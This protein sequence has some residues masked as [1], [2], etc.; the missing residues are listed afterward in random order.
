MPIIKATPADAGCYVEGHWGQYAVAHMVQRAEEYGY[1]SDRTASLKERAHRE[2]I[3]DLAAR[4]L[5]TMGPSG[6]P[7]LTDD[8]HEALSDA[9]DSVEAWLNDNVAPDGYA[10]GWLD[11]EF[12][13]WSDE[14]WEDPYA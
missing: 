11:G 3:A 10:F 7:S 2:D 6:A 8:E 4:K 5:A 13:L 9:S 12:Y 1:A 14:Q